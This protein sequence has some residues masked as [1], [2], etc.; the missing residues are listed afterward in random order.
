MILFVDNEAAR[1]ALTE[2][3]S[4]NKA[5]PSA[6]YSLRAIAAQYDIAILP[7]RVPT[8]EHSA[9]VPSSAGQLSFN[10][11]PSDDL[12]SLYELSPICDFS[13]ALL[14]RDLGAKQ[15]LLASFINL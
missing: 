3:T 6:V 5:V 2:G 9:D 13:W 10:A 14:L 11:W 7:E 4:R 12:A 1:A 8:P 15:L